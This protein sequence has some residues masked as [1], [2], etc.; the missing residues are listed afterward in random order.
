MAI[1]ISNLKFGPWNLGLGIWDLDFLD[2][3]LSEAK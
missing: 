2:V 3:D 1:R